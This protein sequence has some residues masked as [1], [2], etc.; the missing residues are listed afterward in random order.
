MGRW[1]Y[2]VTNEEI[3]QAMLN[4]LRSVR[5]QV[6]DDFLILVNTNRTKATHFAEYVNGT[7]ME[8]LTD[9]HFGDN[10]GGYTRKGL[11]E[12]EDTL[13]WSEEHFR[14]A[15][16]K[17]L[18]GVGHSDRTARQSKQSPLDACLYDNES[19]PFRWLCDVYYRDRGY[20]RPRS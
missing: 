11:Y 9:N 15:T 2:P 20:P 16:D 8:T 19:D 13:T 18:R 10:P 6:R 14:F 12:I 7:F 4:I 5:S 17:L 1:H 3:I